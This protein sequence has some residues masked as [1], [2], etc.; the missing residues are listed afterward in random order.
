MAFQYDINR[1]FAELEQQARKKKKQHDKVDETKENDPIESPEDAP[2]TQEIAP[3]TS[4]TTED[5]HGGDEASKEIKD[6]PN[7]VD[8]GENPDKENKSKKTKNTG[9]QGQGDGQGDEEKKKAK[10]SKDTG[11]KG[12]GVSSVDKQDTEIKESDSK[13]SSSKGSSSKKD[14]KKDKKSEK[15]DDEK[16]E[17]DYF[18]TTDG[19][20]PGKNK[21]KTTPEDLQ[22]AVE[23]LFERKKKKQDDFRTQNRQEYLKKY[24][25]EIIKKIAAQHAGIDKQDGSETYDKKQMLQHMLKHQNYRLLG[26][27]YDLRDARYVQFFIDTSGVYG[28]GSNKIMHELMP[29]VISMLEK[30]GYECYIAAC[31]NGF[32]Q[33][34]MVEDEYY[35]TRKTLEGYKTGKVSKIACPTPQT[36]ARMANEAEFSV[37]LADFDGLSSICQMA[38]LC[39]KDKVPYFLCTEDRYPWEDPTLHDWVDPD[40]CDYDPELVYDVSMD[41][42]PIL[43]QYEDRQYYD[44]Y[45]DYD[46]DEEYEQDDSYEYD[47]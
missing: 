25:F 21:P 33:R 15:K 13:D 40:L 6:S 19:K 12:D 27:K 3:A 11:S 20:N 4:K 35:G 28:C 5:T 29:E 46:Q 26:D 18:I 30:Q 1:I 47:D 22:K 32:Y 2:Q 17:G 14:S 23:E 34:D 45:D 36:A 24:I 37:I 42:N 7:S 10:S 16:Q 38:K 43:E 44:D 9:E 31:G 8:G 41:G 39:Q